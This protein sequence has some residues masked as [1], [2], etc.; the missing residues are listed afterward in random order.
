MAEDEADLDITPRTKLL[1]EYLKKRRTSFAQ[2]LPWN[3]DIDNTPKPITPPEGSNEQLSHIRNVFDLFDADGGGVVDADELYSL[4]HA[5]G[6]SVTPEEMQEILTEFDRD[7]S[8]GIE[9]E[10]WRQP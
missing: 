3:P 10:A 9:Y 8:G 5:L 6:D 2:A 1:R 7:G 4:F